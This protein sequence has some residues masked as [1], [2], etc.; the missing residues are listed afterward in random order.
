MTKA[1][2]KAPINLR[3]TRFVD[4]AHKARIRK[5]EDGSHVLEGYAAV[6]YNSN[7]PGTE[8]QLW[9]DL[10]ERIR[11]SA[12]DRALREK[13]DV[14]GLF[15]HDRNNLLS[16]TTSG[17]LRL[18]V[19]SVGLRYEMDL[20]DDELGRRVA[21]MVER[22]DLSG[23]SFSFLPNKVTYVRGE[24]FDIREVD[25]VDLFDVGPVTYPAYESTTTGLRGVTPENLDAVRRDWQDWRAQQSASGNEADDVAVRLAILN[26][27]EAMQ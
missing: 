1:S 11:P 3:E 14:R 24:A 19:D 26:L 20:A 18:S 4:G 5:R 23:S 25:D 8:F 2:Q 21:G 15:N 10:K 9:S 6:F 7:D 27:E 13:Q 17:T 22:G 16:R 12:F